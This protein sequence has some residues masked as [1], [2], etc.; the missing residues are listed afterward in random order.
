MREL[1]LIVGIVFILLGFLLTFIAAI[2]SSKGKVEY[3]GVIFIGPFPVLG[4]ASNKEIMKLVLVISAILIIVFL[5]LQ[6]KI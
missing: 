6:T 1:L 5:L 2:L 3:G 4:A